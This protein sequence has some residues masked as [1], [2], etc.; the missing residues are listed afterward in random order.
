LQRAV[1]LPKRD[2]NYASY[3][4]VRVGY[5]V[6]TFALPF[7]AVF[8]GRELGAAED[9]VGTYVLSLTLASVLSN[10]VLGRLSDRHGSRLVLRIAA[11][12]LV[13]APGVALFVAFLPDG[14]V[15]KAML[16]ILV[17]VLQGVHMSARVIGAMSYLLEIAPSRERVLYVGFA[18]GIVGVAFF[19]AALSGA[20]VD[21][22]GFRPLFLVSLV[23]GLASFGLALLL[24]EPRNRPRAPESQA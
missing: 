10:V 7:Y 15:D 2:G 8:A 5:V 20:L 18:H 4:G 24:E 12:A 16:L 9:M 1:Q 11:L 13:G 17:F 22:L 21:W 14:S 19:S 23:G 3:L 6:A